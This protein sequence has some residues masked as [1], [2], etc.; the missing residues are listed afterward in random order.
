MQ[1]QRFRRAPEG[2][3]HSTGMYVPIQTCITGQLLHIWLSSVTKPNFILQCKAI[4][5][6]LKY[7]I[8]FCWETTLKCVYSLG[9]EVTMVQNQSITDHTRNRTTWNKHNLFIG[10]FSTWLPSLNLFPL[11]QWIMDKG[12]QYTALKHS[13]YYNIN[14]IYVSPLGVLYVDLQSQSQECKVPKGEEWL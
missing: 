9:S 7:C 4:Y 2:L 5:L 10:C 6:L 13:S 12:F 3:F 14:I 8:A 11:H 1:G